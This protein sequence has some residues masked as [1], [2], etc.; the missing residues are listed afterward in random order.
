MPSIPDPP[1]SPPS[2]PP[3]PSA[4]TATALVTSSRSPAPQC[5][6]TTTGSPRR[7]CLSALVS[8]SCSTRKATA[9]DSGRSAPGVPSTEERSGLPADS[10]PSSRVSRLPD[11]SA[12]GPVSSL[13]LVSTSRTSRSDWRA[14]T[15]MFSIVR[16]SAAGSEAERNWADSAC[17]RITASECPTTSWTSRAILAWPSRRAAISW[18]WVRWVSARRRRASASAWSRAALARIRSSRPTSQGSPS[19]ASS[20][21]PTNDSGTTSA[22]STR[23]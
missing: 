1:N 3:V 21:V 23:R 17:T 6:S 20:E 12:P 13:V 19:T 7:P 5:R 10:T 11:G 22:L 8:I 4:S 16:R 15:A 18:A 14:E 9:S 2:A